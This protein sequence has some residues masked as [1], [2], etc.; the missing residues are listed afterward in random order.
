MSTKKSDKSDKSDSEKKESAMNEIK[1]IEDTLKS[2]T[3]NV[4]KLKSMFRSR[5]DAK[6]K[7]E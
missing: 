2:L 1:K 4:N 6:K 7:N 5:G 3:T